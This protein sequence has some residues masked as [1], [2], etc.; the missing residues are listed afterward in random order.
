[1]Q[2]TENTAELEALLDKASYLLTSAR[3]AGLA[4]TDE[5]REALKRIRALIQDA[6]ALAS[7]V[8]A[9]QRDESI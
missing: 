2:A 3:T 7:S 1:M 4:N 8:E 6:D 9:A 5:L